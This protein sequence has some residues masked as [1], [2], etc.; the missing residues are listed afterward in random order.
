MLDWGFQLER[1]LTFC[2][3]NEKANPDFG[4]EMRKTV[5]FLWISWGQSEEANNKNQEIDLT[6][7]WTIK[8]VILIFSKEYSLVYIKHLW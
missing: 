7:I 2:D 6:R 3:R 4:I 5:N 8:L 1:Q